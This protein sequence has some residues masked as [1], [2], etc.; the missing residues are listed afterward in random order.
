M[1]QPSVSA[2]VRA[3]VAA[4]LLFGLV[5]AGCSS[6]SGACDSSKCAPGNQCIDDGSTK[7]DGT[8]VGPQCHLV[9]TQQSDCPA[10]YYCND[11]TVGSH[12]QP[13]N[14]CVPTT[15]AIPTATKGL[16]GSHCLPTDGEGTNKACDTQEGFACYGISPT[17]ANAFCTQ[18]DCGQ[19]TDCPGGW[20]CETVDL[21]PNVL[22]VRRSFGHTRT[23]CR[24]RQYCSSCVED[25]DCPVT[26][27]GSPQ[28]CVPDPQG[29]M[30]C[31]VA[32]SSDASCPLDAAC[33]PLYTPYPVCT[34]AKGQ[35]CKTDDD[36]PPAKGTFQHC[37][38]G[39]CTPECGGASDCDAD[40]QCGVVQACVP[41]AGTCVGDASF[42]SPCRSDA[43][44]KSGGGICAYADYSTERYCT[45]PMSK[46]TCP[47]DT[48]GMGYTINAPPKA[49]CPSAPAG[50]PA[51]QAHY[52][53]VGCTIV[54]TQLAPADQ[55]VALTSI[56]NG[57]G[58]CG[59]PGYS[60][61]VQVPGC[62]TVNRH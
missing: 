36:C 46:G 62:W 26:A 7:A 39:A 22:T 3:G 47:Q 14:W 45:V 15:Y 60:A 38:K 50:A 59:P 61:C 32:C 31:S 18:F 12:P 25:H 56:S 49:S 5:I 23:V 1:K 24:P 48:S 53:A 29:H 10:D 11:G 16:W 21:K 58:T 6:N 2:S 33:A 41:R 42:C 8:P 20:A 35:A 34:P 9:C 27:N 4:A 13:A 43:D 30:F 54:G 17:D 51:A 37:I 44:C 57:S 52:G 40:Q 55:C 28:R 19:D